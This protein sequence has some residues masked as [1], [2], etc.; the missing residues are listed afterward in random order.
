MKRTA[1]LVMFRYSV[2]EGSTRF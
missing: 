2:V 1:F